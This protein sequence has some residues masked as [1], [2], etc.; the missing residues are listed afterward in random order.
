MDRDVVDGGDDDGTV[1]VMATA[2]I[3]ASM[4]PSMRPSIDVITTI[5]GR[6]ML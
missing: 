5:P 3:H 1:M 2:T 6:A 4:R